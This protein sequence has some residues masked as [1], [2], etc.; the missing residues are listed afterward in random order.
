MAHDVDIHVGRK[1]RQ[2]RWYAGMSQRELAEILGISYQQLQ[3]YETGANRMSVGRLWDIAQVLEVPI[4]HFFAG[5]N[6][7]FED[8]DE[9]RATVLSEKEGIELIRAYAE[10]HDKRR[11]VLLDLA[12]IL[13]DT[14]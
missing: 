3:K 7:P 10:I 9:M 11:R 4:A 2:C 14:G 12:R 13:S 1:V 6:G 8:S 5:I